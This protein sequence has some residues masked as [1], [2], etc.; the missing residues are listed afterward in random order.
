MFIVLLMFNV[1]D[2]IFRNTRSFG[3]VTDR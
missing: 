1:G 2:G 3:A